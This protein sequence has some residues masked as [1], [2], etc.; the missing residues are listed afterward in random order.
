M[1]SEGDGS[2]WAGS[3]QVFVPNG[4]WASECWLPV[5][6]LPS[7]SLLRWDNGVGLGIQGLSWVE[8]ARMLVGVHAQES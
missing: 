1:G 4:P 8:G 2:G 6:W 7:R 5:R 3:L